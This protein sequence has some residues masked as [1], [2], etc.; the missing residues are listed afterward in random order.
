MSDAVKAVG[1]MGLSQI[2]EEFRILD[3][4]RRIQGLS[5]REA[6]LYRTLYE[7]LSEI[8][9]S[10][11]RHRK[12]DR[13]QFLRVPFPMLINLRRADGEVQ[14]IC[15]NFGGGGCSVRWG[16]EVAEGDDL[17]LDGVWIGGQHHPL[18]GRAQVAWINPE[19]ERG[20]EYGLRFC[21]DS[22]E[23]KDQIDRILY[24]VLDVFLNG[25]SIVR[26]RRQT[27]SHASIDA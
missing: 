11:E 25:V 7:R 15:H 23:M 13:R 18:R 5:L 14:V 3:A 2:A 6:E 19:G 20:R 4:R 8:L 16:A 17:W 12:A 9:A 27:T 21:I 10:G 1:G 24:R 26:T 22:H